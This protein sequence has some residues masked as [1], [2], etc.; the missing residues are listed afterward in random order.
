MRTR[1]PRYMT[2]V[3]ALTADVSLS[4][5]R[6]GLKTN[7][8]A[9][10]T[11]IATLPYAVDC[12]GLPPFRF[13]RTAAF[14]FTINPQDTDV[15]YDST[16]TSLTAGV[17]KDLSTA[18]AY[19]E[20]VS[21][22]T[23][24]HLCNERPAPAG[25]LADNAVTTA[26]IAA[27]AVETSD[28]AAANVT[29]TKLVGTGMGAGH[30]AGRNGAGACTL[31]GAAVG[32][33]VLVGWLSSETATDTTVGGE[34][35]LVTRAAFVAL[36]ETAITVVNQIQQTSASDLSGSKYSVILLPAAA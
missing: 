10:G 6:H 24:W 5:D 19:V 20:A 29:P 35:T 28:I 7:T 27:G 3:E 9:T 23:Y 13:L 26:K 33:R 14:T 34:N 15:I 22:G 8:G 36:F 2:T 12:K 18:G 25:T 31:T 4:K 17:A 11:V 30:F 1:A 16:G 21:D 32:D